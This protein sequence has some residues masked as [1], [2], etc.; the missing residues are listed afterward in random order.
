MTATQDH[1]HLHPTPKSMP[2]A[3][4]AHQQ[5]P[6]YNP[7]EDYQPAPRQQEQPGGPSSFANRYSHLYDQPPGKQSP[8]SGA[9][10]RTMDTRS[11]SQGPMPGAEV[12][13]LARPPSI[14]QEARFLQNQYEHELTN[15]RVPSGLY[16]QP[17]TD[18]TR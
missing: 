1:R 8:S 15:H 14:L 4:A 5:E 12:R 17:K 9:H 3:P 16:N 7:R 13:K 2:P 10:N 18:V 6:P 11:D